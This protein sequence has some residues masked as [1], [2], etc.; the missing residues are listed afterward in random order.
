MKLRTLLD[1]TC[2]KCCDNWRHPRSFSS[3]RIAYQSVANHLAQL[4]VSL[5]SRQPKGIQLQNAAATSSKGIQSE[6][7]IVYTKLATS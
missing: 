5:H 1:I 2:D 6:S 3:D 4:G 7:C